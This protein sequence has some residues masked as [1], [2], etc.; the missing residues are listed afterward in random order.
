MGV[1]QFHVG[2]GTHGMDLR[3]QHPPSQQ[4]RTNME[5]KEVIRFGQFFDNSFLDPV[6]NDV[7]YYQGLLTTITFIVVQVVYQPSVKFRAVVVPFPT[8]HTPFIHLSFSANG[9]FT[10]FNEMDIMHFWYFTV[11]QLL[12]V[13]LRRRHLFPP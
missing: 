9:N 12:F 7:T 11:M 6:D 1:W 13:A 4:Q 8:Q 5:W 10:H 3:E 2:H